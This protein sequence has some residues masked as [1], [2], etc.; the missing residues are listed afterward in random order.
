MHELIRFINVGQRIK[1]KFYKKKLKVVLIY[2]S[3][4]QIMTEN[5]FIN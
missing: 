3:I 5:I 2:E 1:L 4:I